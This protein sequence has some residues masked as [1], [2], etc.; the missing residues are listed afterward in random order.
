MLMAVTTTE[1]RMGLKWFKPSRTNWT[2]DVRRVEV[3]WKDRK[4]CCEVKRGMKGSCQVVKDEC[5]PYD[6]GPVSS[7]LIVG[8]WDRYERMLQEVLCNES[9]TQPWCKSEN[10]GQ[11]RR[12][13]N[14][15]HTLPACVCRKWG[16]DRSIGIWS[17]E[18][19][20]YMQV[21]HV[22]LSWDNIERGGGSWCWKGLLEGYW[23]KKYS[24]LAD[25]LRSKA[26]LDI[27]K[28]QE[29]EYGERNDVLVLVKR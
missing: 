13:D 21:S 19:G 12:P 11:R 17:S 10:C 7:S 23:L 20:E 14:R 5:G 29:L 18:W 6:A 24:S 9:S 3:E 8:I 1:L 15:D 4:P 26:L 28:G 22:L 25:M 2:R 27:S 16:I